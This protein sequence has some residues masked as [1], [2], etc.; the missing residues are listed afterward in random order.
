MLIYIILFHY[1]IAQLSTASR[2]LYDRKAHKEEP[3]VR[4]KTRNAAPTFKSSK[5]ENKRNLGK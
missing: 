1:C 2:G 4:K 3:E 5:D